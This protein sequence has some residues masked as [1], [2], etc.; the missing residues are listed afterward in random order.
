MTLYKFKNRLCHLLKS[1]GTKYSR[2]DQICG[3]EPLKNVNEHGLLEA[4]SRPH[5]FKFFKGCLP[6]ILLGP[7]LHTLSQIPLEY[8]KVLSI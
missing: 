4:D 6:H 5:P 1:N 8:W 3:R 2:M 7:V